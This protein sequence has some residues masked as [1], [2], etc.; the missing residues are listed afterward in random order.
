MKLIY[1]DTD[2]VKPYSNNPKNHPEEQVQL[3][4]RSIKEFGFDQPIVVTEDYTVIK[5]HGRLLAAK[6]LGMTSVPCYISDNTEALSKVNRVLDNDL[7]GTTFNIRALRSELNTL[8]LSGNLSLSLISE[9]DIPA[10][11][12]SKNEQEMTLFSLNTTHDCP[13]CEYRW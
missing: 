13:K 2:K 12:S 9:K 4:A 11:L 3:I 10:I 5:G 1:L 8:S 6:S 7:V